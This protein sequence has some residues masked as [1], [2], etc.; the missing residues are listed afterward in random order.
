GHD[1]GERRADHRLTDLVL[2]L[3]QLRVR[4]R[5]VIGRHVALRARIL[6]LTGAQRLGRREAIEA[7][8]LRAGHLVLGTRA[9]DLRAQVLGPQPRD[10][11]IETDDRISL[12]VSFAAFGDY[13]LPAAD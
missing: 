7:L 11:V 5:D 1:P 3:P 10:R 12:A 6:E 9:L 13:N 2:C 4:S 8:Q